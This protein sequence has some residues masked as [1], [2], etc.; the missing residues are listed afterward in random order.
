[1]R[2][3]KTYAIAIDTKLRSISTR[4]SIVIKTKI[5]AGV[6]SIDYEKWN[7][8]IGTEY[9]LRITNFTIESQEDNVAF[10]EANCELRLN[11][12]KNTLKGFFEIEASDKTLAFVI[13]CQEIIEGIS[14]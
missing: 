6:D 13:D 10:E 7:E 9:P 11:S 12:A 3:A 5:S 1:M 2:A 14:E 8:K 4:F